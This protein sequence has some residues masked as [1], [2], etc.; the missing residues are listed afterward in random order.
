MYSL[1]DT[2]NDRVIS[3]HRSIGATAKADLKFCRAVRRA[4]PGGG[5]IPT[6]IRMADGS[7]A[8][9][10]DVEEFLEERDRALGF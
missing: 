8:S 2:F 1:F 3:R 10:D 7:R 5:Y 6:T 9:E 4:N